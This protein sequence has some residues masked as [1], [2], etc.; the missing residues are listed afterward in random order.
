[1]RSKNWPT[2]VLAAG[3]IIR[4]PTRASEP[5]TLASPWYLTSGRL[6]LVD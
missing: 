1:M 2:I 4:A 3:W 5:R 6:A